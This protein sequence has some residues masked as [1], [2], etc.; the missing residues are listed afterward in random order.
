MDQSIYLGFTIWDQTLLFT[1]LYK[2]QPGDI[3]ALCNTKQSY[4]STSRFIVTCVFSYSQRTSGLQN[5]EMA[6]DSLP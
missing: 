4:Q 5:K 1:I 3:F 6:V 2:V